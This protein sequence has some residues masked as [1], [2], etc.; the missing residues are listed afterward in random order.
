MAWNNFLNFFA[1]GTVSAEL[2]ETSTR[3]C[4]CRNHPTSLHTRKSGFKASL[5]MEFLTRAIAR[6]SCQ[7]GWYQKRSV[8]SLQISS[9][10]IC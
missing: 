6:N 8:R 7:S 4:A 2:K 5:L 1:G 10:L 9:A 3:Y